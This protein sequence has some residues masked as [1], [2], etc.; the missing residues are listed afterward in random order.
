MFFILKIKK[1]LVKNYTS[2]FLTILFTIYFFLF[3]VSKSIPLIN[4][5]LKIYSQDYYSDNKCKN[6]VYI[7]ISY[8]NACLCIRLQIISSLYNLKYIIFIIFSII[9]S[10]GI[11]LRK[12]S[13]YSDK[14][15]KKYQFAN[16]NLSKKN[17]FSL[18]KLCLLF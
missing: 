9:K 3:S 10:D 15:K 14:M 18:N 6:Y 13:L 4:L 7:Q 12:Y 11:N 17:I 5:I 2:L 16:F 8:F 1:V